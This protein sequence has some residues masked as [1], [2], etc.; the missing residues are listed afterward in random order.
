MAGSIAPAEAAD[1]ASLTVTL[2]GASGARVPAIGI[3]VPADEAEYALSAID[4][5]RR[6]GPRLLVCHIDA[7]Q[8]LDQVRLEAYRSLA[9]ATGAELGLEIVIPGSTDPAVEL[10]PVAAAVAKAGVTPETVAIS[11]P[12]PLISP[13]PGH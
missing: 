7:R 13:Q 11:P 3:G 2:G 5:V 1:P 9:E 8:T 6:L 12:S 4:L 10:R